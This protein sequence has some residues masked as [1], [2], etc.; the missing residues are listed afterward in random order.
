MKSF[1]LKNSSGITM[2]FLIAFLIGTFNLSADD[3]NLLQKK[4][5]LDA[6]DASISNIISTMARLSNCNI[7]LAMDTSTKDKG[8]KEER[9]ITIHIQDVP[10]EQALALVVKS[11]GLSYRLIGE[12]TFI[13][14]D[15]ARIEE[16]IGER[17]YV[18]NLN[19]VDVDKI[20]NALEI[21][22]GEAVAIEGQNSILIRANPETF[23]EITN[24][25]AEI[26]IPQK[27]IEIRARLIEI[28]ISEA[29]K[30]G[31]D[32]SKLNN[33]TT[34]LA[35][36]PLAENG[37]GLPFN[38]QDSSGE[39]PHGE[40]SPFG[41]LPEDQYFQRMDQLSDIGHFSRQLTAFDITI[42]WLLANNAAQLLTDTRITA[43][44]GEEAEILIGEVIPF[45]VVDNDKQVQV[46]REEVGIKLKIKPTVNK[47]GQITTMIEPEVSSVMELV[48]G[49]VPR[50]KVRKIISTV[51]VPD[52]RKII[53]GG[54]L[55]SN[56]IHTTNKVP[57]LSSI[58]FL[59][60]LF[61]HSVKELK[62]TD[63]I[64]EITPRVVSYS[65][66]VEYNIDENLE[67]HLIIEKDSN[68]NENQ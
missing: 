34:I 55:S 26:D 33:L 54:L 7:V 59:G 6:E 20:T 57:L 30:F 10:I 36:D 39:L 22:P 11:I 62:K 4:I 5:T 32:W 43:L 3:G 49:Y 47:D 66:D 12:K 23:A 46:E 68:E 15:K 56:V 8:E 25:I 65:E 17:T 40:L 53:V 58:P 67:K 18:I 52:G 45:V 64:I 44:N 51:T 13:V 24:R 27:Q 38:Y 61:Q 31:I 21:M 50:T 2:L 28:S 37:A 16:E 41:E 63:L 42:D 60:K 9:K 19:Y 48:G 1:K 14:G 35:E 29:E